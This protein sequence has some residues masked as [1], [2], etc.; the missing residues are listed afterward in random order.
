M[1]LRSRIL[2]WGGI[3]A[4][5]T[6]GFGCSGPSSP[7]PKYSDLSRKVHAVVVSTQGNPSRM[8]DADRLVMKE[9]KDYKIVV[10]PGF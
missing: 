8:T 9:A 5:M 6:I 10:P 3:L 4:A 1:Q 7:D 2:N